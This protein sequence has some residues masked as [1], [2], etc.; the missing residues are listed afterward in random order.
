[1]A[2]LARFSLTTQVALALIAISPLAIPVAQAQSPSGYS[3]PGRYQIASAAS[4]KVLDV[5]L[6]DG[7]TV[8]QW[9]PAYGGDQLNPPNNARNQQWDIEDAGFGFVHIRS[10]QTGMN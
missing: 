6:R 9:A 1:M 2:A 7:R 4:G 8:R 5:D 3:G 10:A